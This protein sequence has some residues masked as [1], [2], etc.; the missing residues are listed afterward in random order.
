MH[1]FAA[2]NRAILFDVN[3]MLQFAATFPAERAAIGIISINNHDSII[4][5]RS[6]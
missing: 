5:T 1:E 4:E 2:K 6:Q 3:K